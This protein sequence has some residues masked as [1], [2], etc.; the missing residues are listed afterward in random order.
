MRR[1][2]S[3]WRGRCPACVRSGRRRDVVP[4]RPLPRSTTLGRA[5]AEFIPQF[6]LEDLS[7]GALREVV[8]ELD[9]PRVLVGGHVLAAVG[10]K[11][12]P[13]QRAAL[14]QGEDGADLLA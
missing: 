12:V 9:A 13:G 5:A 4:S 11:G 2:G 7:G 3:W 6:S 10:D 8:A 14:L 1:R